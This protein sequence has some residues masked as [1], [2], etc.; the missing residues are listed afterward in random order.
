MVYHYTKIN[1]NTSSFYSLFP[2]EKRGQQYISK[3]RQDKTMIFNM[4]VCCK[5]NL[6]LKVMTSSLVLITCLDDVIMFKFLPIFTLFY[7]IPN[8]KCQNFCDDAINDVIIGC[9]LCCLH[10]RPTIFIQHSDWLQNIL[11]DFYTKLK[12]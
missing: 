8:L 12:F 9:P 4:N 2:A 5:Q 3:T 7:Q 1:F 10:I 11:N 6:F